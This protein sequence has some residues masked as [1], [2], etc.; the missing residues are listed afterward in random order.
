MTPEDSRTISDDLKD[1]VW[2]RDQ[3]MYQANY[4]LDSRFDKNM[5]ICGSNENLEF[6][7]IVPTF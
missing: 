5:E 4:K 3:G 7:H 2:R 1:R 6:D